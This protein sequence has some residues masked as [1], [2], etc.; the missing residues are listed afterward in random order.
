MEGKLDWFISSPKEEFVTNLAHGILQQGFLS[1]WD[2]Q[3]IVE[4][5]EVLQQPAFEHCMTFR[6]LSPIVVSTGEVDNEGDLHKKYL[7]PEQAEFSRILE[8]NLRGKYK[9]CYGKEP[10]QESISVKI[11][12]KPQ[13]KL[14]DYKGI[15]IKGWFIHF[16]AHGNPD[17]LRI[18]YEAGFGENNSAGFGMME[19]IR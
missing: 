13:S 6:T 9:A 15:K 16:V 4:Q 8:K 1:L 2:Q 5:V 3:L 19:V 12:R 14:I 18:G 17:L 10:S 11:L 7:S